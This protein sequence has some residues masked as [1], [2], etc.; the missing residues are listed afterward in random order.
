ML[1]SQCYTVKVKRQSRDSVRLHLLPSL[2]LLLS[3]I[4]ML[5]LTDPPQSIF[6]FD[7]DAPA[8]PRQG[9]IFDFED[10]DQTTCKVHR[11]AL[12]RTEVPAG[13]GCFQPGG[14]MLLRQAPHGRIVAAGG[15]LYP[16]SPR[17]VVVNR[18]EECTLFTERHYGM[19]RTELESFARLSW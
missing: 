18:C 6:F 19:T 4:G 5:I 16:W 10:S 8:S 9:Y 2:V 14:S 13:F 17:T 1:P 3:T 11:A 15:M 7:S 12:V